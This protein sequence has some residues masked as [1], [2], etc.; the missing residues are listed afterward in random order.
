[1]LPGVRPGGEVLLPNQW[2]LRPAG[3]QLALG[4]FPVNLALHPGG[5]SLAVLHAGYGT[6]EV[7][8]IRTDAGKEKITCRV[9]L[10]QVFY[11][12]AWSP[13]GATLYVSGGE[14]EVM[15]QESNFMDNATAAKI[16]RD[17]TRA[18]LD[19]TWAALAANCPN[20]GSTASPLP[21][22]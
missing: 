6:H 12:L 8:I 18:V 22:R 21:A 4:D 11:G 1:M 20:Y 19:H 14:F 16:E 17:K 2:S 9:P 15:R 7:V 13:D 10:D 5:D 3:K